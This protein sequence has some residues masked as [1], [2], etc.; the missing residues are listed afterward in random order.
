MAEPQLDV[1]KPSGEHKQGDSNQQL[2]TDPGDNA[3]TA[4]TCPELVLKVRIQSHKENDFIE[5][6]LDRQELSYQ[7]LLQVS[8][9]ELG[10]NPEQV[11]KIRKL[12]NTL[13]R[14]DKDILR[15]QDFQEVELIL[16]KN[17]SSELAE[18]T[19]SLL[20]KPCYNSNAA[21]MTY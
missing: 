4:D 3:K 12:P 20:E 10:I 18:Y 14:K 1:K 7:N 15:L 11:E 16:M 5:V 13:L 2:P 6:E 9:Y 19:P 8:C 17:G 21:K